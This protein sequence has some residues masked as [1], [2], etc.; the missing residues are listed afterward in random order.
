MYTKLLVDA[1]PAAQRTVENARYLW[2]RYVAHVRTI[3]DEKTNILSG[4]A[5]VGAF[6]GIF[7]VTSMVNLAIPPNAYMVRG[8]LSVQHC[9]LR[10]KV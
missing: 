2:D 9:T 4:I 5:H 3:I 6:L 8:A 10:C 7:S 1:I